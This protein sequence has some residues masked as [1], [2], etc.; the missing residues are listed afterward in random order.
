MVGP[1]VQIIVLTIT[2]L[3]KGMSGRKVSAKGLAAF[4]TCRT[5]EKISDE[6]LKVIRDG[7]VPTTTPGR[8][9]LACMMEKSHLMKDGRYDYDQALKMAEGT[10]KNKKKK[11]REAKEKMQNCN[12]LTWH[13]AERCELAAAFAQCMKTS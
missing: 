3:I 10:L 11:L 8:C 13:L 12:A 9:F 4:N 1:T 2:L 6:E 7:S 5:E